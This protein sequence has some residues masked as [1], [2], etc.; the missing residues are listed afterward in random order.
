MTARGRGEGCVSM[1]DRSAIEWT[2]ATWNPVTGCS[3]VSPGCANCYAERLSL[4]FGWSK[5]PWSAAY[6]AENV[7]LHPERLD[8]PLRWRRPRVIF[9]NSMSDLF[10]ERVPFEFVSRAFQIMAACRQHTFQIL[11][12]RPERM[13]E[14]FAATKVEGPDFTGLAAVSMPDS[15]YTTLTDAWPLSNVWLGTSVEDQR[16][17][18]ERI[19]HLL[20]CPAAMRFLSCE[21]LLT[22][23]DLS[24]WLVYEGEHHRAEAMLAEYGA[25]QPLGWV[26]AGGESGPGARPAHPDWF[27]S[28]RDQCQAAGVPFFFKQWGEW[29][30]GAHVVPP[31][32]APGKPTVQFESA[33]WSRWVIDP[34]SDIRRA[35]CEQKPGRYAFNWYERD[36]HEWGDGYF[37][38]LV[39]KHIAGALLDG[40]LWRQMPQGAG[41]EQAAP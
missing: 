37:S 32:M 11:T 9:V 20:R 2:D 18:E 14:W 28:L 13:A 40:R 17:A 31:S 33:D 21:P 22:E 35:F 5:Y 12:K 15:V 19:P 38:A 23:V 34:S 24:P 10:H 41:M 29:V 6:A 16:R 27:R 7:V 39:G 1:G 30:G 36:T 25:S 3:K 4:R 8:A 26:I